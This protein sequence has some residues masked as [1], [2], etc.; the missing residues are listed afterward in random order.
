MNPVLPTLQLSGVAGPA[1]QQARY[2]QLMKLTGSSAES[3]SHL[4]FAAR[5]TGVSADALA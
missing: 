5:E 2:F 4:A 1:E 3:M